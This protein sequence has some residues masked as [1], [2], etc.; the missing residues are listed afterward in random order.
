MSTCGVCDQQRAETHAVVSKLLGIP[1]EV[2]NKCRELGY[3]PRYIVV[4]A[5]RSANPE[6]ALP[7]IREHK[8]HGPDIPAADII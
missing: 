8:Y 6:A 1:F 2:C 4:L 3:E 7:Y 5:A